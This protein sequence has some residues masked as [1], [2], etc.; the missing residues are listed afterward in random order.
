VDV[1]ALRSDTSNPDRPPLKS[2]DL[3]DIVLV[4]V[5]GGSAPAPTA[6]DVAR[7][8]AVAKHYRAKAIVLYAWRNG[9]SSQFFRL[10]RGSWQPTTAAEVFGEA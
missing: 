5:K 9:V 7:L 2:G 8:Q 4:Q 10:H 6:S 3:F 1:L